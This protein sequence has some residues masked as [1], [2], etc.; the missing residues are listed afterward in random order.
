MGKTTGEVEPGDPLDQVGDEWATTA[1]PVNTEPDDEAQAD[2]EAA[3]IRVNIEHTRAEMSTTIDALQEK[4]DPS[5][6]AEQVKEQIRER[7]VEA[8]DSAKESLREATIGR[9]EKIMENVSDKVSD[10]TQRAGTAVS[11]TGSRM[12]NMIRENPV[13]FALIGAGLGA[14][15]L[16]A[17]QKKQWYERRAYGDYTDG[18]RSYSGYAD[19]SG[20]DYGR[21]GY[22]LRGQSG[23]PDNETINWTS[24]QGYATNPAGESGTDIAGKAREMADSVADTARA[25]KDKVTG[26][27]SSAAS[28]VRDTAS[29]LA[30]TTRQQVS[31]LSD[32][33]RYRAR[34]AGDMLTNTFQENPL[35]LGVAALAAG[36]LIGL[37]LPGTRVESE[38]MGEARDQF[39]DKAKDVARETADKVQRVTEEAGKTLKQEAERNS[40]VSTSDAVFPVKV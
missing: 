10:V 36:A 34:D 13:A 5:R 29:S 40:E 4:L 8:Y 1:A 30:D 18:R 24:G 38:Y 11:D 15:A 31:H 12:M 28:S 14:L 32:E 25:A 9:A 23:Y 3:G 39:V 22:N 16:N 26:A 33:A 7:A 27:V 20:Q 6:I 2:A 17:R 37:V 35:A 19:Y 21:P